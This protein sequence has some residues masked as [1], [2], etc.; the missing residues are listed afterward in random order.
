[1]PSEM[2]VRCFAEC[3]AWNYVVSSGGRF[4][5]SDFE[6]TYVK[7]LVPVEQLSTVIEQ[8]YIGHLTCLPVYSLPSSS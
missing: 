4:S 3:L 6:N 7:Y 5:L 2:Q 8:L 1:M